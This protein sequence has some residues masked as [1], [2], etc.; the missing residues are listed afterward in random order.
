VLIPTFL[1]AIPLL[2]NFDA[3]AKLP[4]SQFTKMSIAPSDSR[5]ETVG[6][7]AKGLYSSEVAVLC[8]QDSP[9]LIW[10]WAAELY[11][12]YGW[13]PVPRLVNDSVRVI[14]RNPNSQWVISN[15]LEVIRTKK[16]T[17]VIDASGKGFFGG[18]SGNEIV[19]NKKILRELDANYTMVNIEDFIGIIYVPKAD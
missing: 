13:S 14:S 9:V 10:G 17:C 12:Y 19:K 16:A 5:G 6:V 11:S 18:K 1:I 7:I 8:P 2:E 3:P 15:V 4:I